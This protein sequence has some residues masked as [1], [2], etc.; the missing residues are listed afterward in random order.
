MSPPQGDQVPFGSSAGSAA[1]SPLQ[2]QGQEP[3]EP[4]MSG[5]WREIP[6]AWASSPPRYTKTLLLCLLWDQ[7]IP[8]A[9]LD[10][11]ESKG[12]G[13]WE[14]EECG[15]LSCSV[16]RPQP[17]GAASH[18][19]DNVP[20]RPPRGHRP[21]HPPTPGGPQGSHPHF[22]NT[23]GTNSSSSWKRTGGC[24]QH[25]RTAPT[26][27]GAP[28]AGGTASALQALGSLQGDRSCH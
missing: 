23:R 10:P 25:L 24:T 9:L 7:G 1:P 18:L 19:R 5:P 3:S 27:L 12:R 14:E 13:M 16:T 26:H 21:S 17:P 22:L 28:G 8:P 6:P 2:K 4:L 15:S 11:G 20:T